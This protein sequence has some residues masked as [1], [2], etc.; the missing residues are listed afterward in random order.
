MSETVIRWSGAQV[1]AL[2]PDPASLSAARKLAAAGKWSESGCAPAVE[3]S[4]QATGP[5]VW[6]LCQ[7]S[8]S[9]PYQICVDLT[10]P[11][12]R[13]SCPSRKFP[14]KHALALLVRFAD[15]ML[16]E[17]ARPDWVSQWQAERAGRA[18]RKATQAAQPRTEAQDRAATK[19]AADRAD[20]VAGGL[21]ELEQWLS[22]Q[23]RHGFAGL[24]QAGYRQFD[25]LAARL[26]DAQAPGL[27]AVVRRLSSL[28][29]S[30]AGW[31][32]R[33]LSEFGMLRLLVAAAT[34]IDTLPAPLADTVNSRL[35][36]PVPAEQV[37][38]GP[39]VRDSWQV[40][41]VRDDNEDK[42]ASRRVWLRG[43][44]TG[45]DAMVLS[46]A[47][48]GQALP[49]DLA[50]GARLDAELCYYPGAPALRALVA[51]KH[52]G[53]DNSGELAGESVA[54]ALDRI[55]GL[56][57]ADPWLTSWPLLLAA[58]PV[59]GEPWRLVDAAGD[60]LPFAPGLSRQAGNAHWSMVAAGG[61]RPAVIAAEWHPAGVRPLAMFV[62]A[63][64]EAEVVAA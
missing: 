42:L 35:G 63:G 1:Q 19:R 33:V 62:G 22:D 18:V 29:S 45:R 51:V 12:Y 16:A 52:E 37:L 38:A 14:C 15:G 2:A 20:R 6:G 59:P 10:A 55:A 28:P 61:G 27:A 56:L 11:A 40:T 47:A 30:G 60:A 26:V 64:P 44:R 31:E 34:R 23:V 39:R 7:G 36:R 9:K 32:H 13:C 57:A 41:A 46:F 4:D 43:L 53:G 3:D 24:D 54:S 50:L 49:A 21:S 48:A 17:A 8:G 25:Q 5:A 58:T